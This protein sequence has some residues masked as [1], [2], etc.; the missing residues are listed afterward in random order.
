[1]GKYSDKTICRKTYGR[2]I[3]F[4]AKIHD[5]GVIKLFC[6]ICGNELSEKDKFCMS[7][8]AKIPLR[9]EL[10]QEIPSQE[11]LQQEQPLQ[12]GLEQEPSGNPILN[13]A[14]FME[15]IASKRR[16]RKLFL[17]E[18]VDVNP[19]QFSGKKDWF[20]FCIWEGIFLIVLI[21]FVVFG[22][23][24]YERQQTTGTMNAIQAE[25]DQSAADVIGE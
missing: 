3:S 12:E 15:K 8:G 25:I 4:T 2:M 6:E 20:R 23:I 21:A 17:E 11:E 5:K 9:K 19:A 10:K 18:E 13:R 14:G 7:C 24:Y 22:S 1:M 16:Q